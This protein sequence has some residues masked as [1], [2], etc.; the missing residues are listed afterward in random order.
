MST[1]TLEVQSEISE[2]FPKT[3]S[4]IAIIIALTGALKIMGLDITPILKAKESLAVAKI[5]YEKSKLDIAL[6]KLEFEM[7]IKNNSNCKLDEETQ[8]KINH[9]FG[10]AHEKKN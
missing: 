2:R 3:K 8:E 5:Q 1:E 9:S 4:S 6:K 7:Y 10:L